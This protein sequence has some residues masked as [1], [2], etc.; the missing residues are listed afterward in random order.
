MGQTSAI[1]FTVIISGGHVTDAG[2]LNL[3]NV[4]T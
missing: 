1:N 4:Y 3:P 2:I